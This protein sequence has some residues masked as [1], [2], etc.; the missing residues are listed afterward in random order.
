MTN[1]LNRAIINRLLDTGFI[2]AII[3]CF[4]FKLTIHLKMTRAQASAQ[5]ATDAIGL[6]NNN[7]RFI[8]YAGQPNDAE[9]AHLFYLSFDLALSQQSSDRPTDY[10]EAQQ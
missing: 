2:R 9:L 10:H 3:N 4:G 1:N 6:I 5:A 8:Y 7:H